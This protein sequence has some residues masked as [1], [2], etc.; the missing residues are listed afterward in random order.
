MRRSSEHVDGHLREATVLRVSKDLLPP[1]KRPLLLRL[2]TVM[3]I[4][5]P[6]G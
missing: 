6:M 4:Q 2:E 1:D 3:A 5:G